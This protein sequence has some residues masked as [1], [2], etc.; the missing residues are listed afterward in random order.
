M[1]VCANCIDKNKAISDVV[2]LAK[3]MQQR[4]KD[5]VR[6]AMSIMALAFMNANKF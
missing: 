3:A 5:A 1:S 2:L 4:Q 6:I